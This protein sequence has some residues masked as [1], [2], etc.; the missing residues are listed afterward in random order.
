MAAVAP[1][2]LVKLVLSVDDCH[3][4]VPVFPERVK[5]VLLEPEHTVAAPEIVPATDT[6]L[7]VTFTVLLALMVLKQP[8]ASLSPERS[9]VT[10]IPEVPVEEIVE[11]EKVPLPELTVIVAVAPVTAPGPVILYVTVYVPL[12]NPAPPLRVTVIALLIHILL[13]VVDVKL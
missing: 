9:F 7:T 13:A 3:C 5:V 11:V 6:G 12:G 4:T 2:I 1:L 10:V 8:L